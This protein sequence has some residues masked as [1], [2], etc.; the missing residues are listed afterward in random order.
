MVK[1][2]TL[3]NRF[4]NKQNDIK[5]FKNKLPM[6]CKIVIEPF[7]GTFAVIRN[8]Y[9]NDKY[10]KFVNDN[11]KELYNLYI[12]ANQYAEYCKTMNDIASKHLSENKK[13]V[14]YKL[15][16]D[17]VISKGLDKSIFYN[18]WKNAK[19]AMGCNI[20]YSKT[21]DYTKALEDISK[22]TFE[23]DDYMEIINKY[24]KN[25]DAFLFLD[26]P[27]LFSD[28]STYQQQ[29]FDNDP[30]DIL[31]NIYN[32]LNDK[33]TKAKIMFIINDLKILRWL[34]KDFIRGE[35]SKFYNLSKRTETHLII[36]NYTLS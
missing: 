20:K 1:S 26:P 25:K 11:D 8:I 23:N 17:D 32:I 4:G 30:T 22:I 15:F 36:C 28:N 27:Y 14:N 12:N 34:F 18:E 16:I 5:Y 7:G 9:M 29:K 35:Y 31:I 6:D 21:N 13:H 2:I 24:R 33:T 3:F 19:I 10:K